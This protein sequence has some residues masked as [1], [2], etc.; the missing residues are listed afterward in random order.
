LGNCLDRY[1]QCL[2]VGP[3]D[4]N[5]RVLSIPPDLVDVLK[6]R[7]G[8]DCILVEADGSKS[9]PFKA[10]GHHEPVVPGITTVLVPIVGLNAIGRPLDEAAVHRPEIVSS[11]ANMPIGSLIDPEMIARTLSHP[12]G[13]AKLLPAGARLVPLLNKADRA[14]MRAARETAGKLLKYPNVD[15][16]LIGTMDREP[17][18]REAWIPTAGIILAAGRARRYGEAKQALPWKDTTLAANAARAALEAGLDPVVVVVGYESERVARPL[19]GL[20]VQVSVNED[21]AAGQSTSIRK[22]IDAL[23]GQPLVDAAVIEEILQVRRKTL[24]P[25]CVPEFEG[26][27][28]NPVLFDRGLFPELMSLDGDQGGRALFEKHGE[29]VVAVPAGRAVVTD[30]DTPGDYRRLT[31]E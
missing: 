24:A 9:R 29:D 17:P 14:D 20:P 6:A 27:R 3:P 12:E 30:I 7:P 13:G 18:V 15:S 5:G 11:L 28:G 26:R 4:G 21:F 10:P 31:T 25:I 1:G 2:L 19:A 22:G 23:P 16:V 8:I